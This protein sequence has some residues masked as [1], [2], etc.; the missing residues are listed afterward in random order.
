[1]SVEI[2]LAAQS[3]RHLQIENRYCGVWH[4]DQRVG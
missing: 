4:P 3:R 2:P 1:L